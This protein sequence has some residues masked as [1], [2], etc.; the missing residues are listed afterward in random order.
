MTQEQYTASL[1]AGSCMFMAAP[2][3]VLWALWG[4]GFGWFFGW[5]AG[6]LLRSIGCEVKNNG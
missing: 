1:Y 3:G 4:A 2:H 6:R 5:C